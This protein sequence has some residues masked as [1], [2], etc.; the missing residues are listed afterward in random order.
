[1]SQLL[2]LAS[3][4]PQPLSVLYP[5]PDP[6]VTPSVAVALELFVIWKPKTLEPPSVTLPKLWKSLVSVSP[7]VAE[8]TVAVKP[9]V[10]EL[11]PVGVMMSD[12]V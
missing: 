11:P 3:E 10:M 4:V 1:M 5:A 6:G 9:S 12:P 8:M 2:P 7:A